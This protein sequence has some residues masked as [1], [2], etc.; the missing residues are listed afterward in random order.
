[1]NSFHNSGISPSAFVPAGDQVIQNTIHLDM[2][3]PNVSNY[4]E[5]LNAARSDPKFEKLVQ[6]MTTDR[7]AGRGAK[8][9]NSIRW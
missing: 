7:L 5:F 6:A 8:A 4:D 1:M 2:E 9:K 3:L